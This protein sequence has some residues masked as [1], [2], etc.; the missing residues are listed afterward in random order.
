MNNKLLTIIILCTLIITAIITSTISR[1][2]YRKL[3]FTKH[4]I[5]TTTNAKIIDNNTDHNQ[6]LDVISY[7]KTKNIE[8]PEILINF[9]THS[10]IFINTDVLKNENSTVGNWINYAL[11]KNPQIKTIYWVMPIEEATHLPLRISFGIGGKKIEKDES[12]IL[13]GNNTNPKLNELTFLFTPLYKKALK[14]EFYIDPET[15][16]I[17]EVNEDKEYIEDLFNKSISKLRKFEVITCTQETL[18]DLKDKNV[19]LSIDADYISN[20]GYDTYS[21]FKFYKATEED[22]NATIYSIF[23]TLN[24]KNIRPTIISLSTSPQYLP[25]DYEN[26]VNAI[27]KYIIY[28][29]GKTDPIEEY[30]NHST[31]SEKAGD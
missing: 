16:K 28:I 15:G 17:N 29:S 10:D 8:I 14:Q 24:K 23:E 22:V 25:I 7:A 3:D 31:N 20:S 27:F 4:A 12:F 26:I 5:S 1:E 2:K 11:A 6:A 13:F 30:Q 19:F 9:D 18:P 21:D